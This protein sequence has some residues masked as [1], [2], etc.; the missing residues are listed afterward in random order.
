MI[1][2][3]KKQHSIKPILIL[4]VLLALHASLHGGGK[5]YIF[6]ADDLPLIRGEVW[7]SPRYYYA[8]IDY[9]SS[10][11]LVYPQPAT[12]ENILAAL[13]DPETKAMTIFSHGGG[14]E[15][16]T[17]DYIPTA[18]GNLDAEDWKNLMR[19]ALRKRYEEQGLSSQEA[20]ARAAKESENFGL[21]S[22]ANYSCKSSVNMDIGNLFVKPGG[23]Y[24]GTPISYSPNPLG[25]YWGDAHTGLTKYIIG[26]Q[27]SWGTGPPSEYGLIPTYHFVWPPYGGA[28]PAYKDGDKYWFYTNCWVKYLEKEGNGFIEYEPGN[29]PKPIMQYKHDDEVHTTE[30]EH[31]TVETIWGTNFK[32]D[33]EEVGRYYMTKSTAKIPGR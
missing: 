33:G 14:L 1:R 30:E 9:T 16:N 10:G 26:M 4:F 11:Y 18:G 3:K 21:E 5:A 8:M 17:L 2:N 22:F 13:L 19:A 24:W 28:V 32:M 20:R 6:T 7:T 25:V 15:P 29:P 27:P 23:V 12:K 31:R